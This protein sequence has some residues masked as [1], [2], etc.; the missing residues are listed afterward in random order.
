M[1]LE[2]RDLWSGKFWDHVKGYFSLQGTA[3]S[4]VSIRERPLMEEV[5]SHLRS[6]CSEDEKVFRLVIQKP[7]SYV[8]IIQFNSW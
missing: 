3:L 8:F 2:G 6:G 1:Y 7:T 5:E 4:F